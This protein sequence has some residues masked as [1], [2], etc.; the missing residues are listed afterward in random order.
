[1][2]N[3]RLLIPAILMLLASCS[4]SPK[5]DSPDAEPDFVHTVFFWLNDSVTDQ[6]KIEFEK[7]LIELGN[8]PA[9]GKYEYGKPAGTQREVVDN[10]YDYAI[11]VYFPDA[12]AQDEYQNDP[13]HLEFIEKYSH[14]WKEVKV[15]DTI[16]E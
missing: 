9:I 5:H 4:Q 14:L 11:V 7:G 15:Y 13:L 2:K 3:Y 12:T 1:M 10:S 6:D 16:L 8:V